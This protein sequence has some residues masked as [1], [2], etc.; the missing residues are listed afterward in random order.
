MT[1]RA[2]IAIAVLAWVATP[3]AAEAFCG[4][5]VAGADTKLYN[6]AT[7]VAMMRD[8][9]RT[10][11]SMQNNYQGPAKDFA[12][13]VPVPVVLQEENVR[14]LPA[15]VFDRLDRLASPRLVEYWEQDPCEV[16]RPTVKSGGMNTRR[17]VDKPIE[18]GASGGAPLV[19]VEAQFAVGEYEIVI[20]SAR[21]ATALE[22]WI[23][24][25]GYKIPAGA[26]QHL[27]PYVQSGWKFFVAKVNPKKV[28]FKNGMAMLSPLRFHYDTPDFALPIRLGLINSKGTQDLIVHILAKNQRYEVANYD[29]VAIPTNLSVKD[30]VRKE[31]PG[32]Y[33]ALFDDTMAKHPGA[34]IT[35]YAWSAGN[36][37]PCPDTPLQADELMTLGLDV[38][39]NGDGFEFPVDKGPV[40]RRIAPNVASQFVLTR[41]H[42]RY[43]ADAIG[44][45]LVFRAAPP[46]VGGTGGAEPADQYKVASPSSSNNYQGRYIIRHEWTGKLTCKNPQRGMWGGPPR[47]AIAKPAIA[48]NLGF[49]PRGKVKLSSRVREKVPALVVSKAAN[50]PPPRAIGITPP[51]HPPASPPD[52][53]VA[54]AEI[55][56]VPVA[57][58]ASTPTP[59]PPPQQ[60]R[61]D[62]GCGCAADGGS[63]PA[64]VALFGLALVFAL[65]RRRT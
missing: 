55:E 27:A 54:V 65:R 2:F 59:E 20:L 14:T 63:D 60:H 12:M 64:G 25:N 24:G 23:T 9:T 18:D 46:I 53:G 8:G 47:G 41:L 21:E 3:R 7:V 51:A 26:A 58:A 61:A 62:R 31:F 33:T 48:A 4:F 49:A 57:D 29:N 10:V 22:N 6:N 56:P 40:R 11:L 37:D 34:V 43:S 1:K 36:C 30:R 28:T 38:L 32:F 45:D 5:Y 13:V 16:R 35:E 17:S 52:A 42:A 50:V 15:A 19:V 44:D 39:P